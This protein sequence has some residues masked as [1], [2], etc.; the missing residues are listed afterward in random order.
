[1]NEQTMSER[2]KNILITKPSSL[3]DVVMALPALS[4]LRRSFPTAKITWM[5]RPE[6]APLIE[7]HPHLDQSGRI[8]VVH[9]GVIENF[10]ALKRRLLQAG[11]AFKSSTDTEVLAHLIG[12]HYQQLKAGAAEEHPPHGV[13]QRDT[14]A[15]FKRLTNKTSS[16]YLSSGVH[17]TR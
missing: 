4:A 12:E 3:G 16:L 11:H 14:Q 7:G 9:N 15:L 10:E 8:A 6:F 5:I 13:T 1:M 2:Y 17:E